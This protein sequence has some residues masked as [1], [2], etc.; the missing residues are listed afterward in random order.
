MLAHLTAPRRLALI[1]LTVACT[2]GGAG[3]LDSGGGDSD[4]LVPLIDAV[5]GASD[6]APGEPGI[7]IVG[8]VDDSDLAGPRFEW[9]GTAIHARFTGTAI[10]INLDEEWGT[11]YY[12]VI[13]D[14]DHLPVLATDA[15]L[16][17]YPLATG[18]A[19][20]THELVVHR[21]SEAFF[22]PTQLRG[23]E[24]GDGE[25]LAPAPAPSRR[26]EVI[27]D[28][29]TCGYGNEGADQYCSFTGATENHYRTYA[30]IAARDLDADLV[31]AAWSGI[32]IYR[33][34]D[35]GTTDTMP[36]RYPRAIPTDSASVWDFASWHPDVVVIN[37]GTNDFAGG[38]PAQAAFTGAYI[39]FVAAIRLAYPEA[40]IFCALGSM[41]SGSNLTT[42]R[43]YLTAV[44]A[45][46]DDSK[47]HF[48][49]F[50][51]QAAADGYGCDWHP[52]IATN[53]IMADTLAAAIRTQLGW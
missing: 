25:L 1:V 45:A 51:E 33:N 27:G 26:I 29:I 46:V 9:S 49:E 24:L 4:A 39:D 36:T 53:E 47:V 31:A 28:S 40:H 19:D 35:G 10:G 7:R 14:G 5:P 12:E 38:A 6:A 52:S 43:S 37:L 11:N 50:A 17:L 22:G 41:L 44:V 21:R 20:G 13:V 48:V 34:N 23:L 18:L 3:A 30:A 2:S 15:G 32:G 8:R 42:A 16:A